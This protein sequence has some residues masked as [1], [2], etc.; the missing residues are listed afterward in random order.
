MKNRIFLSVAASAI[1]MFSSCGEKV[2]YA[3]QFG[4]LPDSTIDAAPLMVK[5]LEQIKRECGSRSVR[6]VLGKGNYD[7]H[8]ENAAK[9]EYY[10]SN[11]DQ[12]NPKSV[13]IALEDMDNFTLDGQGANIYTHG[14]MIPLSMV[15]CENSRVMNLSIDSRKPQISQAVVLANDTAKGA[16]TYRLEKEVN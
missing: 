6:L 4:I 14:R 1:L 12:D 16:I 7:F 2:Y 5:A 11:H 9:R 10:I 13:A 15:G 8:P 3:A